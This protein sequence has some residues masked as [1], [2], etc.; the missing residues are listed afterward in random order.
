MILQIVIIALIPIFFLS[1]A[2]G[3]IENI[4]FGRYLRKN[5]PEV[6]VVHAPGILKSSSHQQFKTIVWLWKRQYV[7]VGDEGLIQRADFHRRTSLIAV[8]LMVPSMI[9][10]V[11]GGPKVF[12]DNP[13]EAKEAEQAVHGNT[14]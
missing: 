13:K 1:W 12:S 11:I 10:L 8:G 2:I 4:I 3:C 7:D 9:G 6:A 5:H 14:H